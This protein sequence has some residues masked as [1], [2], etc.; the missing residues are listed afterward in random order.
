MKD[1]VKI[2]NELGAGTK[3]PTNGMATKYYVIP[4]VRHH[5]IHRAVTDCFCET[6]NRFP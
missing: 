5:R 3:L 1:K 6:V 4:A 2:E